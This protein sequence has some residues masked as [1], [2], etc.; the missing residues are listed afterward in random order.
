LSH[1]CH[2]HPLNRCVHTRLSFSSRKI[3]PSSVGRGAPK[4]KNHTHLI[5]APVAIK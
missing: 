3:K 1:L 4:P 2:E 5:F